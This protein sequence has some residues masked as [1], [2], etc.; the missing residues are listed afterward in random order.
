MPNLKQSSIR[1]SSGTRRR[2][3]SLARRLKATSQEE[4]IDRALDALQR[5][6]FW[7]GFEDE[8]DS[9]LS[10]YTHESAER[11]IFGQISGDTAFASQAEA[12]RGL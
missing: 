9:Y 12:R 7:Q 10:K 1:V 3:G 11:K 2:V 8:A 6:I 4:V 5:A